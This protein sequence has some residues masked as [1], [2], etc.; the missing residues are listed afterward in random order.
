MP[1]FYQDQLPGVLWNPKAG[2]EAARFVAGLFETEDV[3]LSQLLVDNG[4]RYEGP[5]PVVQEEAPADPDQQE[6][7]PADPDVPAPADEPEP[8]PAPARRKK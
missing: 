7:A 2:C 1:M 4:Y 5:L 8:A 3:E 6:E